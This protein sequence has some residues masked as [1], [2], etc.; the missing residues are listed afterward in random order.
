MYI[1]IFGWLI[2]FI[3]KPIGQKQFSVY[4]RIRNEV[5]DIRLTKIYCGGLVRIQNSKASFLK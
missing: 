2:T 4:N 5:L 3:K 1:T